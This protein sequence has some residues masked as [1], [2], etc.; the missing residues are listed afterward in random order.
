MTSLWD[1]S[2][3]RPDC[4]TTSAL[5]DGGEFAHQ[6]GM[7]DDADTRHHTTRAF[8]IGISGMSGSG[9]TLLLLAVCRLLRDN[10]SLAVLATQAARGHD[11]CREFLIRHKALA[12]ARVSVVPDGHDPDLT[13]DALMTEFRPELVFLDREGDDCDRV[14]ALAD[15]RLHVVDGSADQVSPVDVIDVVNADLLALNQTR[16][17]P[18]IDVHQTAAVRE[19]LRLRGDAPSVFTQARYGIGTIDVAR[20]F[21]ESWRRVSAPNAWTPHVED[22]PALAE[23]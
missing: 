2:G 3:G 21:L 10:Y 11:G 14:D 23:V 6:L 12:P 7:L 16:L 13:L 1:R 15:Y 20:Q 8:T 18:S 5:R 4:R 9:R 22:H 17:G 19:C